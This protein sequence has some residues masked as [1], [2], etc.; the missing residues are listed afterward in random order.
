[1]ILARGAACK[2]QKTVRD[3]PYIVIGNCKDCGGQR[4]GLLIPPVAMKCDV[5]PALTPL[6]SEAK[7]AL[8]RDDLIVVVGLS[9]AEADLY[10]SRMFKQIDADLRWPENIDAGS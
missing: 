7:I 4:R 5:A 1:V 9:F 10:I 6:L 8:E 2:Y 3:S